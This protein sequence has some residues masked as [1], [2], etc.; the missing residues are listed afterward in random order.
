[1]LIISPNFH[2]PSFA[3]LLGF[4]SYYFSSSCWM[5]LFFFFFFTV[6]SSKTQRKVLYFW[7]DCYATLLKFWFF[8][9][10]LLSSDYMQLRWLITKYY[11]TDHFSMV[12]FFF[13]DVLK[14]RFWDFCSFWIINF[15]S[16]LDHHEL[17]QFETWEQIY[18][19]MR[20]IVCWCFVMY[21]SNWT[22]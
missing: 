7:S 11:R 5:F 22:S 1:M 14:L 18:F 4:P 16:S 12:N 17:V 9:L 2:S 20:C 21:W 3:Q 19:L 6:Q 15:T 13:C 10:V 8:F